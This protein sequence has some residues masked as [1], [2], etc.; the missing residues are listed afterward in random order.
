MSQL[1][2]RYVLD[3][4]VV[5]PMG[6]NLELSLAI[7]KA[8]LSRFNQ[9]QTDTGEKYIFSKIDFLDAEDRFERFIEMIDLLINSLLNKLPKMLKPIPVIVSVPES[10]DD[11]KV[12]A[13]L[14]EC[15]H[16]KWLSKFEIVH[17]SGPRFIEQSLQLLEHHD[18]IISVAADSLFDQ[19]EAFISQSKVMG[20]KNPWGMIP[21]EGGAGVILTRKNIIETLK[22]K[23][24]AMLE[25]FISEKDCNDRRGMM[26]LVRNAA[27]TYQHLGRVYTDMQ[28]SRD[29]TEDYGFALGAKAEKFD[30]PQQPFLINDLW[31][32]LGQASSLALLA[33]FTQVHSSSDSASLLMFGNNGDRGL[34]TVSL[35][36]D[37][38]VNSLN[39]K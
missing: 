30:N 22:L 36:T 10:V 34:L 32:T 33:A 28:N 13:W 8:D 4:E 14:E 2:G 20:D 3:T 12:M 29:H 38:K 6:M 17:S 11:K 15:E 9:H 18:A 7:A 23:P 25:Y 19:L 24:L 31:G 35:C 1:F 27:L 16:S 39:F 5:T 26:K 37:N 21:S